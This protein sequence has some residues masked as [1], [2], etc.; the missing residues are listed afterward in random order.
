MKELKDA[1]CFHMEKKNVKVIRKLRRM[2]SS[3]RINYPESERENIDT[4][5]FP[6]S[7]KE[8]K[9]ERKNLE[10]SAIH[11]IPIFIWLLMYDNLTLHFL[12]REILSAIF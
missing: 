7:Y 8:M 1:F 2:G 9:K 6:V 10:I 5:C 4:S 11:P 3:L 12:P